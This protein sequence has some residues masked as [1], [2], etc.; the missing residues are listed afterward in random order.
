MRAAGFTGVRV[1]EKEE[2]AAIIKEWMPG[3]KAEE[4]VVAAYVTAEKPMPAPLVAYG[5]AVAYVPGFFAAAGALGR[6]LVPKLLGMPF[7]DFLG[8]RSI[9]SGF[10]S[11][12]AAAAGP[13]GV[14]R[15]RN[16]LGVG[17]SQVATFKLRPPAKKSC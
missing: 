11:P 8:R 13:A 15:K 7:P 14:A 6:L 12:L 17:V 16:A 2:S 3:S 1:E 4:Y 10:C 5:A 9:F